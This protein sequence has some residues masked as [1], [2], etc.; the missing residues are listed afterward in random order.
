MSEIENSCEILLEL[1]EEM[2]KSISKL[3]Y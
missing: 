2:Y 1:S 3:K